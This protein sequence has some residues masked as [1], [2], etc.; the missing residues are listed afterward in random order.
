MSKQ[1]KLWLLILIEACVVLFIAYQCSDYAVSKPTLDYVNESFAVNLSDEQGH[2]LYNESKRGWFGDGDVYSVWQFE[3]SEQLMQAVE[4]KSGKAF[5]QPL[6]QSIVQATFLEVDGYYLP[7]DLDQ[8]AYYY[9]CI[10]KEGYG[11]DKLLLVFTPQVKLGDGLQYKNLL[12][13][14]EYYS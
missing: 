14:V 10:D 3:D 9:E 5:Q 7:R 12:F 2:Q 11:D 13:V 1:K 4:W 6:F 8:D